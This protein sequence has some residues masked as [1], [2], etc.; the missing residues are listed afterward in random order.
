MKRR[1]LVIVFVLFVS[2]FMISMNMTGVHELEKVILQPKIIETLSD[3]PPNQLK[4][5]VVQNPSF[6]R[7][8]TGI[9]PSEF[10]GSLST[11]VDSDRS[12]TTNTANGTYAGYLAS[13]GIQ[14]TNAGGWFTY[15]GII[16]DALLT[17]GTEMEFYWNVLAN[18]DAESGG[19][20]RFVLWTTNETGISQRLNYYFSYGS[21]LTATNTSWDVF[22]LISD[23]PQ[24]WNHFKYNITEEYMNYFGTPDPTRRIS[25]IYW[26]TNSPAYATD[27]VEFAIDDVAIFNDTYSWLSN[28][29]F[30]TGT[31]TGWN[32][33]SSSPAYA[34]KSSDSTDG[35]NSL[36]LTT[37]DVGASSYAYVQQDF[38]PGGLYPHESFFASE[39]GQA[40]VDF[41]YKYSQTIG[42]GTR[43]YSYLKVLFRN[44][45]SYYNLIFYMGH[46]NDVIVD[47]NTTNYMN[48]QL[49]GF[50]THDVWNHE[51]FDLYPYMVDAKYTNL[52]L[53]QFEVYS[54]T[55]V[56]G[57]TIQTL[58][59]ELQLITF[60]SADPSFEEDWYQDANTPFASWDSGT[61]GKVTKTTDAHS[62]THACNLTTDDGSVNIWRLMNVSLTVDDYTNFWW[63]LDEVNTLP[64]SYGYIRLDFNLGYHLYY[65]LA[66]DGSWAPSNTSSDAYYFVENFNQVGTWTNLVRNITGD[67]DA[68]FGTAVGWQLLVINV[69]GYAPSS[70]RL[71][72]L[73]D[74]MN[75]SDGGA[76]VV[77]SVSFLPVNPMYYDTVEVSV[78]THDARSEIQSI[79]VDYNNGTG[80]YGLPA[81]LN[82]DHY[83]ATILSHTYDTDVMFQVS[84][85][86]TAGQNTVDNNGGSLYTYTVGDDIDPTASIDL[87]THLAEVESLVQINVT[88]DDVAS[89]VDWVD[90]RIDGVHLTSDSIYPYYYELQT[91]LYDLGMHEIEVEVRDV[92][93]NTATDSINI[94]IVDT[95]APAIST[96]PDIEFDEGDVGYFI[97]WDP[98]DPR[99]NL[100][101][102]YVDD[103]LTLAGLWNSSSEKFNI[104]LD[105][106]TAG[107]YNYTCVVF[108]DA[109]NS[110]SDTVIVTVNEPIGT[111]SPTPTTETTSTTIIT[112]ISTSE[113]TTGS[114]SGITTSNTSTTAS[115]SPTTS[116]VPGPDTTM[117]LIVVGVGGLVLLVIV[118]VFLRKRSK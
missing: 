17:Y 70:S 40:I 41:K 49:G 30:E 8:T 32:G 1:A 72:F 82:V 13:K 58:V 3:G 36:N 103:V 96:P 116:S 64:N 9:L 24:Q 48:Y 55:N 91:D 110:M 87:P 2:M 14:W 54:Y 71:S 19:H 92:A 68:V 4:V 118:I 67:L 117:L 112:T 62:G 53:I 106:L 77:D 102:I 94:T 35:S 111:T 10:T 25:N 108:D 29:D 39:P 23:S 114:T 46:Y 27:I 107:V 65:I 20:C 5:N 84:V 100:F 75:L 12:Y 18:P 33:G 45:S 22:Y 89:G 95:M 97:V 88:A 79:Y 6:E 16:T 109:M 50:Y 98:G 78:Y 74:D 34:S 15:S 85:T 38:S 105:G 37:K 80:W 44:A 7:F 76:P 90:F 59:D 60:P 57:A 73:I 52:A 101:E 93:G 104:S 42:S 86:D 99:P 43:A 31:G 83:E 81:L 61:P 51:R 56:V 28:G 66:T 69:I 26:Y 115:T 113:T 47:S 63:R 11:Y 21:G